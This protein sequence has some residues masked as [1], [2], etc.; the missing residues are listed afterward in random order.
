MAGGCGGCA[1]R[2]AA[3]RAAKF[4]YLWT[5]H[6]RDGNEIHT[7]YEEEIEAKAKVLK[8]GGSYVPVQGG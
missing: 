7:E 1:A 3:R 6:D 8:R 2:A 5:G 4:K